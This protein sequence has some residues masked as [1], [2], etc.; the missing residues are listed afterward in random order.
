[1]LEKG[2]IAAI[3][4]AGDRRHRLRK[5]ACSRTR[6]DRRN[7]QQRF[8]EIA[9]DGVAK[10]VKRETT[11]VAV[12]IEHGVN[13]EDHRL[14]RDRSDLFGHAR[15]QN[16]FVCQSTGVDD[17]PLGRALDERTGYPREHMLSKA[18]A[19]ASASETS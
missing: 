4:C 8:E 16:D 5:R 15:R 11:A 2:V 18:S 13:F 14:A 12:E 1:T 10:A 3:D 19:S 7:G 9:L 17:C 6:S